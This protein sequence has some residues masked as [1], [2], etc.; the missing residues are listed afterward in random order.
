MTTRT[1][2]TE[3]SVN[4]RPQGAPALRIDYRP[5]RRDQI[6]GLIHEYLQVA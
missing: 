4:S 2:S 3:P 1:V 6:G 5:L